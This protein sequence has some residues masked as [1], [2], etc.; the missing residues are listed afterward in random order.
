MAQIEKPQLPP[1]KIGSSTRKGTGYYYLQ[2]YTFH[3]DP[4]TKKCIRDSQKTVGKTKDNQRYGLVVWKDEFL[5]EH[6]ELE[7]FDV[8]TTKS[9]L[10]FKARDPETYNVINP[11]KVEKKLAGATWAIDKIMAQIGIGDALRQVFK[12]RNQSFKLASV[13]EYMLI[14]RTNVMHGYAPFSKIHWLPWAYPLNDTQLNTLFKGITQDDTMALFKALNRE[15]RRKFGDEFFKKMFLALDSTSIS[16]YSKKLSYAE[17]GHNKDGDDT[18]QIN[19]L[20]V[21]EES[22]GLPIYGKI[23]KGNVVDVSTVKNLLADLALVTGVSKDEA[24]NNYIFVTDRGYE[25]DDNLQDFARHDYSFVM[26]SRMANRWIL[27]EVDNAIPELRNS[28]NFDNYLNQTCCTKKIVYKYDSFPVNGKNKSNTA[29]LDL[30]LHM[31][32]NEDIQNESFKNLR[33]NVTTAKNLYNETIQK[34]RK[35][36]NNGDKPTNEPLIAD[37]G[38]TQKFID[39]YCKLDA[40]GFAL[41]DDDKLRDY[42]KY[43]GIMVLVTDKISDAKEAHF[44]YYRRQ[45]VEQDFETFKSR[46][47]G[48]RPYVSDD[49]TLQGRFLCQLLATAI[50][51]FISGRIREYEKSDAAKSD[52]VRF[53]NYSQ[54]RLISDL[55]TI[56]LTSFKDGYYFDEIQGKYRTLYNALGVAVPEANC[57]YPNDNSDAIDDEETDN[58][59]VA[60]PA[61]DAIGGELE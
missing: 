6:P 30:F 49:R 31:Y 20:L 2:T 57:K 29:K 28:N 38:S 46:L 27:D 52:N 33:F 61:L 18:K 5:K 22:S 17:Y 45:T 58:Y 7:N 48:N 32:F 42:V 4:K 47:K 12:K 34:L 37:I 8:Y 23:Y 35:Q 24:S 11:V 10:E 26:R 13:I 44:A 53:D 1:I 39:N 19:F 41:I 55:D 36:R 43:K 51:N 14:Q 40:D 3:Y 56:M 60:D 50:S 25:S 21:C 16:T 9:G 59:A 15:Y 54:A